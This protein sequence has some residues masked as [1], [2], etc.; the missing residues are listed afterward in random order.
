[1]GLEGIISMGQNLFCLQQRQCVSDAS[2]TETQTMACQ[3]K[4]NYPGVL[5][6][7]SLFLGCEPT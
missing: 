1:M 3:K 5:A 7:F 4:K 6:E 2:G